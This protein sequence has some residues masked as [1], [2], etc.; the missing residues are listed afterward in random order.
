MPVL[1]HTR[2]KFHLPPPDGR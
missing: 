1:S 2:V